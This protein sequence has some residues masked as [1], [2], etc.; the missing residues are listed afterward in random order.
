MAGR[1]NNL[2]NAGMISD[3]WSKRL[4]KWRGDPIESDLTQYESVLDEINRR[5]E[6]LTQ[7]S[8]SQLQKFAAEL[9][10]RAMPGSSVDEL[11][12]DWFA[13]AREAAAAHG[14]NASV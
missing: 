11:L 6:G 7:S 1:A 13:L 9:R 12:V 8:D 2:W 3:S 10:D 4:Q 14:G 5:G